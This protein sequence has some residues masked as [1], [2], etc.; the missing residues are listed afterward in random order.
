MTTA[1]RLHRLHYRK[2]GHRVDWDD[3]GSI[4]QIRYR[5][6]GV[7]KILLIEAGGIPNS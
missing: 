1:W 4:P 6:T 3:K 2:S 5:I 7:M